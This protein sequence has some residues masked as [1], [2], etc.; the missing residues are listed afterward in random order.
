MPRFP[1]EKFFSDYLQ[2]REKYNEKLVNYA[3]VFLTCELSNN[4]LSTM[5]TLREH[6]NNMPDIYIAIEKITHT[7]PSA[8][9]AAVL[10]T[11]ECKRCLQHVSI[12]DGEVSVSL[13]STCLL[14]SSDGKH[15]WVAITSP[16]PPPETVFLI[17][18]FEDRIK[19]IHHVVVV[20]SPW[21]NMGYLRRTALL[22]EIYCANKHKCDFE[23]ALSWYDKKR[24]TDFFRKGGEDAI[25]AALDG[26]DIGSSLCNFPAMRHAILDAVKDAD[27]TGTDIRTTGANRTIKDSLIEHLKTLTCKF[28]FLKKKIPLYYIYAC[29]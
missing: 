3:E 27:S 6:F 4:F 8:K 9:K 21:N 17:D 7:T 2:Q 5:N 16:P 28:L 10:A 25:K 24:L 14:S 23:I 11:H 13:Q 1:E 15:D 22:F 26:I 20:M 19:R 29:F 18:E 12:N